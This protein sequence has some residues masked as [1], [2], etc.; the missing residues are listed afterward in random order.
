MSKKKTIQS[1]ITSM[2]FP[3]LQK[4]GE[5]CP[6]RQIDV[7]GKLWNFNR[8]HMREDEVNTIFKCTVFGFHVLHKWDGGGVPFQE[9]ELQCYRRWVWMDRGPQNPEDLMMTK[10]FS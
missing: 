8:G 9:M 7:S 1:S 10:Y 2:G 6:D 4:P 5:M 3:L